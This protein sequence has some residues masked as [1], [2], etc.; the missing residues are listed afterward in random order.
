MCALASARFPAPES[1]AGSGQ[2]GPDRCPPS[3][4]SV[5]HFTCSRSRAFRDLFN[6][7]QGTQPPRRLSPSLAQRRRVPGLPATLRAV[8]GRLSESERP[9]AVCGSSCVAAGRG[10]HL[11][12]LSWLP[13]PSSRADREE[14]GLWERRGDQ[15]GDA[16]LRCASPPRPAQRARAETG[17]RGSAPGRRA[18][19]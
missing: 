8:S 11:K 6:S 4:F 12:S 14:R 19:R 7:R 1:P 10:F 9:F 5:K 2:S 16:E 15:R 17:L 3:P 13:D 18:L